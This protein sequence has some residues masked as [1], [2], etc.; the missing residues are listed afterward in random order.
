MV[1]IQVAEV[2]IIVIFVSPVHLLMTGII[3][4]DL[5]L[6][7]VLSFNE[8]GSEEPQSSRSC[9][10]AGR[11]GCAVSGVRTGSPD[12]A[13]GSSRLDGP[14]NMV[15]RALKSESKPTCQVVAWKGQLLTECLSLYQ[16]LM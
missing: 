5:G 12:P 7:C 16:Y 11:C 15:G 4:E 3:K 9:V 1:V 13:A 6:C 14:G 2:M 8:W 10:P